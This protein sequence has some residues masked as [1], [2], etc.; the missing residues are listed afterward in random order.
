MPDG[1]RERQTTISFRNESEQNQKYRSEPVPWGENGGRYA[2]C[3]R[4]VRSVADECEQ[5]RIAWCNLCIYAWF[6]LQLPFRCRHPHIVGQ[7]LWTGKLQQQILDVRREDRRKRSSHEVE[8]RAQHGHLGCGPRRRDDAAL[9]HARQEADARC[10]GDGGTLPRRPWHV[11]AER[12]MQ[13]EVQRHQPHPVAEHAG[14]R[15][16]SGSVALCGG[17]SRGRRQRRGLVT[18][19]WSLQGGTSLQNDGGN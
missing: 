4:Y 13:A 17:D 12:D 10:E 9:G 15:Q 1:D 6:S 16:V 7:R 14:H 18:H 8:P 3:V 11:A 5:S 2:A 19:E